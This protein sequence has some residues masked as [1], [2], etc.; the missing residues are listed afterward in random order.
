MDITVKSFGLT[1]QKHE[2]IADNCVEHIGILTAVV[3]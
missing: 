1:S 3:L 2:H